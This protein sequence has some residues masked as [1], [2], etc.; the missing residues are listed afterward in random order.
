MLGVGGM[1]W[2]TFAAVM[3]PVWILTR[4]RFDKMDD[5]RRFRL[6]ALC[7]GGVIFAVAMWVVSIVV[8]AI[9]G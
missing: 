7:W 5:E 1:V 2:L 8:A 6:V 9:I 4:R 3:L